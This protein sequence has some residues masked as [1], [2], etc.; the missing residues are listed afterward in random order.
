[1]GLGRKLCSHSWRCTSNKGESKRSSFTWSRKQRV[2][3]VQ[4]YP[5]TLSLKVFLNKWNCSPWQPRQSEGGIGFVFKRKVSWCGHESP[6][7]DNKAC[8]LASHSG[9]T[10]IIFKMLIFGSQYSWP[11]N[12]HSCEWGQDWGTR[13]GL[14]TGQRNKQLSP[15]KSTFVHHLEV[16]SGQYVL[17]P[18]GPFPIF[19]Y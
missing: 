4:M 2:K 3:P 6:L 16:G 17:P 15:R 1:M 9:F 19:A 14:P 13:E 12:I 7:L 10:S 11:W 18:P 5:H 8:E